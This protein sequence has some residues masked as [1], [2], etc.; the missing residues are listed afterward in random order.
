[1]DLQSSLI[2]DSGILVGSNRGFYKS[3]NTVL[4]LTLRK[5]AWL[6]HGL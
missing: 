4:T 1:M 3:F 2:V 6:G 5:E